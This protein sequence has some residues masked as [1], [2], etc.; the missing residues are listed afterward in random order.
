MD[1][2]PGS[3]IIP[4]PPSITRLVAKSSDRPPHRILP[5]GAEEE[6]VRRLPESIIVYEGI[7]NHHYIRLPESLRK[8]HEAA[9]VEGTSFAEI[10]F[11]LKQGDLE[12]VE[13]LID[14]W[15]QDVEIDIAVLSEAIENEDLDVLE[16][17]IRHYC[18]K[19]G[20]LP[21]SIC[22]YLAAG[23]LRATQRLKI[24]QIILTESKCPP[25]FLSRPEFIL[26]AIQCGNS[27]LLE[28]IARLGVNDWDRLEETGT[29]LLNHALDLDR[30]SDSIFHFL[31]RHGAKSVDIADIL[32]KCLRDQSVSRLERLREYSKVQKL[33]C[34]ADPGNEFHIRIFSIRDP[35]YLINIF[36]W[37]KDPA[38][39]FLAQFKLE[40]IASLVPVICHRYLQQLISLTKDKDDKD[41]ETASEYLEHELITSQL[42]QI[43][44]IRLKKI[45][46]LTQHCDTISTQMIVMLLYFVEHGF[47]LFDYG[48][49]SCAIVDVGFVLNSMRL[50]Q[51][52]A[53]LPGSNEILIQSSE[54]W[55][56][57]PSISDYLIDLALR[58]PPTPEMILQTK[59]KF[60]ANR[61]F[62][63][64]EHTM[65][66]F[67]YSPSRDAANSSQSDAKPTFGKSGAGFG[68]TAPK[69]GPAWPTPTR[70]GQTASQGQSLN[71]STVLKSSDYKP[72]SYG[73]STQ[74]SHTR[75]F[76]STSSTKPFGAPKTPPP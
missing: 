48:R 35:S 14:F 61:I 13:Y 64:S 28:W 49:Y 38:N 1:T 58:G 12:L 47:N 68:T 4:F 76:G 37:L 16:W 26:A 63:N 27:S 19:S 32:S 8:K 53:T 15:N 60:L 25:T 45:R 67:N 29:S 3:G 17:L 11:A 20:P 54:K 40:W 41:S 9:C 36:E 56:L 65:P 75:T 43:D 34:K 2:P 73:F 50:V 46:L 7:V 42:R 30:N 72:T 66:L 59:Q 23:S 21:S 70:F 44:T 33:E 6:F 5:K 22:A 10:S 71:S 74:S 57:P 18:F 39:G 24:L 52:F 55:D 62:A 31:L 51:F 69:T